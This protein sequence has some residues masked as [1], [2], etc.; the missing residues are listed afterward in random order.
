[1]APCARSGPCPRA[2][3]AGGEAHGLRC[4]SG[5]GAKSTRGRVAF[6]LAG[7]AT[8]S[9]LELIVILA[10]WLVLQVFVLPKLGV[11]T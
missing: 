3:I 11:A 1:M 10:A 7:I 8:M 2:R 6:I 5:R 4:R 9:W